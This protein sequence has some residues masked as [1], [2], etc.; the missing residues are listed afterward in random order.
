MFENLPLGA[1]K[2][3]EPAWHP[4]IKGSF[5]FVP[6]AGMRVAPEVLVLELYREIFFDKRSDEASARE[7]IPDLVLNDEDNKTHAF[8][9]AEQAALYATRGRRKRNA[10]ASEASFYTPAYPS[11][12]RHAWLRRKSDRVVKDFLFRALSQM[13][14]GHGQH[15]EA[16]SQ[17]IAEQIHSALHG[18][19]IGGA[20]EANKL[21]ILG[22]EV[23][24]LQGCVSKDESME[25]IYSH[26]GVSASGDDNSS[27]NTV[28]KTGSDDDHLARRIYKDLLALCRLEASID[29]LQWL[30]LLKCFLRLSTSVWMLAHMRLTII[31]RDAILDTLTGGDKALSEDWP[32]GEISAR[33]SD[34]LRPSMTASRQALDHVDKY[35][36]ARVELNLLVAAV[37]KYS[38]KS[39]QETVL[40]VLSTGSGRLPL[41][42]LVTEARNC[43]EAL[44]GDLHGL[45]LRAELTRKCQLYKAWI[46]PRRQGSGQGK[47]YDEFLRVLRRMTKGDEDGSYLLTPEGDGFIVFPGQLML[48]L[49]A[50]FAGEE[51]KRGAL[52]LANVETHFAQYGIDFRKSAGARPRLISTLQD[53]GMLRGSPDAGDSVEIRRPFSK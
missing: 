32:L 34:L 16:K 21:D 8:A 49:V 14:H 23:D 3:S 26:L 48:K 24:P 37:E 10:Q 52:V 6:T 17:R 47:N 53:I 9:V 30:E 22:L 4:A 39:L 20:S 1:D 44:H 40:T 36:R 29:R 11:L 51:T 28:F 19:N 13:I 15:A 5:L 46:A 35:M 31:A 45:S 43:S 33:S 41:R 7:I 38:G 12:A 2:K 42:D 50:Y 27:Y 25:R 18:S